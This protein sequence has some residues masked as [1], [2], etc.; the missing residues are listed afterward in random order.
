MPTASLGSAGAV[1]GIEL[2]EQACFVGPTNRRTAA[3]IALG[4]VHLETT[5]HILLRAIAKSCCTM[6]NR[7]RAT[8]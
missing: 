7:W 8:R 5:S 1:D 6:L 3:V 2:L 4:N